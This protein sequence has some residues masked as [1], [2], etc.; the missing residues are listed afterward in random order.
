VLPA[1]AGE[2]KREREKERERERVRERESNSELRREE[3]VRG[4]A[5]IRRAI[6]LPRDERTSPH[7]MHSVE[8]LSARSTAILGRFHT[9]LHT[10]RWAASMPPDAASVRRS[11]LVGPA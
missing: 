3:G 7:L 4:I 5:K 10:L 6:P 2:E 11:H 1:V 9:S 8:T